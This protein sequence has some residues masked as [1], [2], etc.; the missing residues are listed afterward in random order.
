MAEVCIT[1][2]IEVTARP[3]PEGAFALDDVAGVA[4]EFRRAEALGLVKC[5]R[6]WRYTDDVG[7]DGE[8]PDVSARDA[9]ALRELA[10]LG[11]L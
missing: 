6:S 7:S 8:F 11:R 3:A 1:S 4:V 5:A 2:A 10:A 9:A